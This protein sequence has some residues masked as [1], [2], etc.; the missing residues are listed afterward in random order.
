MRYRW[1][2]CLTGVSAAAACQGAL[3]SSAV[4][5]APAAEHPASSATAR[6]L[7]AAE[8]AVAANG[9]AAPSL[10]ID[11]RPLRVERIETG[12]TM[13]NCCVG[14]QIRLAAVDEQGEA[15]EVAVSLLR[16]DAEHRPPGPIDLAHPATRFMVVVSCRPYASSRAG[17]HGSIN[18]HNSVLS[19][20]LSWATDPR[21]PLLHI[22]LRLSSRPRDATGPARLEIVTGPLI[23]HTA[24]IHGMDQTCNDILLMDSL[25]GTCRPNGTCE[26]SSGSMKSRRSGRCR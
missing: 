15:V 23:V 19:G 5:V 14:E 1:L 25:R 7:G 20:S 8:H 12:T 21:A 16:M 11:G 4:G 3:A 9:P 13:T 18:A 17:E 10:V 22:S 6:P 24:C 26:C 2:L